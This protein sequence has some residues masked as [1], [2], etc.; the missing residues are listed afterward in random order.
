MP[1]VNVALIGYAFMGRAHSNA[2]RQV[3]RFFS[4]KLT[5]RLKVICGRNATGVMKAAAQLGWDEWS[6]DWR[7]VVSRPDIHIVDV[8]TPGDSHAEITI[9]AAKAGKAV[10]CEKPLA[11]TAAEAKAMLAAVEKARVPHMVCHNYR[12]APAV[13]LAQELVASGR[14]GRIYHYRGTYLQDWVV[15][16][17]LPLLWRF[18]RDKAGSGALG[19]IA[20]HSL[21][22]GRFVLGSEITE[23]AAALE[24]YIRRR[25]LPE[26]PR[27]S[28]RVTV[29]DA[30]LALVRFANG[31][32]GSIE[33]TRLAPGRKNYNRFEVNGSL[34]S[35][36]F[37]LERMNELEFFS[38][39]DE[40]K[41]QGFRQIMVTE[42]AHHAYVEGWWPPGHIIGYE[43][44]FTH[45]VH[46]FLAALSSG[47]RVR[48]DF[49]D[50][51]R[52]QLVLE[53]IEKAARTKR[54]VKVA[55]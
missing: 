16:P 19:D 23:V 17:K 47:R 7:E 45:T 55:A 51:L 50:G 13:M 21:D 8:S 22:L 49:E 4:P 12:R 31:A 27:K 52:N 15:D 44:T 40:A 5:P 34:G 37:N 41:A 10:L 32:M 48:P 9:A 3:S 36:A 14:L 39:E 53:A 38:R 33:G 25:P 54:W 6:T 20:S 28:G 30:A 46:D 35:V 18:R 24:T 2:W 1:E 43:H 11:N 42:P 29:D 26:N